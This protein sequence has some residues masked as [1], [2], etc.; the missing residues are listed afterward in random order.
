[1]PEHF[2]WTWAKTASEL[3]RLI[4]GVTLKSGEQAT[5]AWPGCDRGPNGKNQP[6]ETAS[7][8]WKKWASS[9]SK[10]LD[11][12]GNPPMP[13]VLVLDKNGFDKVTV[14]KDM[15]VFAGPKPV[16]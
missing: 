1:M 14:V 12:A 8:A 9:I 3:G 16:L 7:G 10:A 4:A 6:N 13:G 5:E 2:T 11:L 15:R